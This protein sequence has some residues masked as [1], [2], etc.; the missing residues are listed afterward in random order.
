MPACTTC[1]QELEGWGTRVYSFVVDTTETVEEEEAEAPRKKSKRTAESRQA[2]AHA[3][4][5]E[6]VPPRIVMHEELVA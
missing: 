4:A 2:Q 1:G 5:R 3:R 6:L